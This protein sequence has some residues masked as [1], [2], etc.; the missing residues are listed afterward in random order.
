MDYYHILGITK[1]ATEEDI[2]RAY[3]RLA[4]EHHPDRPSGNEKK[5]KEIN[6]AYQVLSNKEKRAQYDRFGKTFNGAGGP[7][8]S[9][10]QGGFDGFD[11]GNINI[12]DFGDLGDIF[13]TFFTGMGGKKRKTYTRGSDLQFIQEVTLEE[14]YR[15]IKK[16]IRFKAFES[17]KA[18]AGLGYFEKEGTATC[19]T[20]DGRGEIKEVRNSFFGAFQQVRACGKCHGSGQIPNRICTTCKGA[21]RVMGQKSLQVEILAG[22]ADGQLIKV[23]GIGEVGERGASAG[24]L[25]IQIRVAPH[26]VFRRE[27][28]DLVVTKSLRL[29]DLLLTSS[30]EVLTIGGEKLI[31]EIPAGFDLRQRLRVSGKGMP[32]FGRSGRGDLFVEFDIRSPK[33]L[34][35]KAK[36]IIEDL[37]KELE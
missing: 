1:A 22:V 15:G 35:A 6:E 30:F 14:A 25:Y 18:C 37:R 4:Q 34:S 21:S 11:F 7:G 10:G 17:C 16:E 36:K 9:G 29:T 13:E 28:D 5:F 33:K 32:H 23:P 27:H 3:R 12:N 20:C 8:F 31:I 26:K 2:K 24:D 19:T